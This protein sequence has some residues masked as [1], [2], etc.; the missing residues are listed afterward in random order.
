MT[1]THAPETSAAGEAGPRLEMNI[2]PGVPFPDWSVV[3]SKTVRE[4]LDAIIAALGAEKRWS[5]L[6][7]GEDRVR[8]S[9]LNYYAEAGHSPSPSQLVNITGFGPD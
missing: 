1:A 5:D 8:R 4:T 2:R 6:E 7:D 3:D 9:I